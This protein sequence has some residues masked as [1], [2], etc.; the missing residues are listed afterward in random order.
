MGSHDAQIAAILSAESHFEALG[1]DENCGPY[2]PA[3]VRQA[4]RRL[5]LL[6]HP[7]KC[8]H[9]LATEAFQRLSDAF[10]SLHDANEQARCRASAARDREPRPSAD[11]PRQKKRRRSAPQRTWADVE[12]ELRRL[13]ELE[14]L[15]SSMQRSRFADRHAAATLRRVVNVAAELDERACIEHNE[16]TGQ[17]AS[18]GGEDGGGEGGVAVPG[19]LAERCAAAADAAEP[20]RLVRLLLYLREVHLYCYFCAS[21]F[22][23]AEEIEACCP[24]VL[25]SAH[26]G[27]EGGGGDRCGDDDFCDY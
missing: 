26:E 2:E 13:D 4:F 14:R 5:A 6:V 21:R 11:G 16:L 9:T 3:A 23:S 19:S 8:V 17:A 1:L 10:E 20:D 15:Y 7:D 12:R 24:G 18:D 22:S 25:E 27:D